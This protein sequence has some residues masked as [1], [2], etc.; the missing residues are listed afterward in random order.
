[1][2]LAPRARVVL[3][4]GFSIEL[5]GMRPGESV[6]DLP[7][8]LQRLIAHLGLAGPPARGAIAGLLWPDAP[9]GHAHGSLRSALW[10]LQK[11]MPGLVEI[12]GG[13]LRL[14]PDVAVDV[15]EFAAWARSLRDP[16]VAV[17]DLLPADPGLPGELLPGWYEDWVLVERE[18]HRQMRLHALEVL[19]QRLVRA[20]RHDEAIQTAYDAIRAEPLRESA[21]RVLVWAHLAEGNIAEALVAYESFCTMLDAELGVAPSEELQLLVGR[22][23]RTHRAS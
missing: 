16:T 22:V 3:L 18:R 14:A 15:R 11:V 4:D 1:M 13:A 19:A 21:H 10:R 2:D 20:G 5:A 6:H 7:R 17:D 23:A 8:G 9:E 12:S